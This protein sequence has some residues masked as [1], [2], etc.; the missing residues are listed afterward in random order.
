MGR[1]PCCDEI[2]LKKG[3]WTPEEDQKLVNFIQEHG[4]R[5]WRALPKLAGPNR[6]GKSCR[7]RW[8]NYLRPDIKRGKLSEEEQQTILDLHAILGNKWSAIASQLPGR[9]DNEIKNFWN[10]HLKKKPIQM[11]YDPMTHQPRTDLFS[12]LP[13]LVAWANLKGLLDHQP[14]KQSAALKLQEEAVQL[15]RHQGLQ[16]ILKP[17]RPRPS[18]TEGNLNRDSTN[19]D[20]INISL[21]K[22]L[23]LT[24]NNNTVLSSTHLED[25]NVNNPSPVGV[26]NLQFGYDSFSNI[27]ELKSPRCHR[28]PPSLSQGASSPDSAWLLS[29]SSSIP[30]PSTAPEI[31]MTNTVIYGEI[32]PSMWP[33]LLLEDPLFHEIS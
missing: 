1:S 15:I 5:S 16:H 18:A 20:S 4:H 6:C 30:S 22:S 25:N 10:T 23:D 14:W 31:S 21:L 7:L 26:S 19:S 8:T 2:G 33:D 32:G 27:P 24:N 17:K 29:C 13:R 3:P 12:S 28:Q 9:T 11:G